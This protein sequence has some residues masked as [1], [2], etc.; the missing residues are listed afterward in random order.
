M[1]GR[2]LARFRGPYRNPHRQVIGSSLP[3]GGG[4][5]LGL[6]RNSFPAFLVVAAEGDRENSLDTP[7]PKVE[8]TYE[9]GRRLQA[10]G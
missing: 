6:C 1:A 5:C 9:V 7:D 10:L 4:L 2:A 3:W 8:H